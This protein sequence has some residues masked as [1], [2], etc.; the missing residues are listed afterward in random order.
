[1][2][3]R[4]ALQRCYRAIR[5]E[6]VLEPSRK[7]ADQTFFSKTDY[8]CQ[9]PGSA[10]KCDRRSV[11]GRW[12]SVGYLWSG[13]VSVGYRRQTPACLSTGSPYGRR[14]ARQSTGHPHGVRRELFTESRIA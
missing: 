7:P 4:D 12:I 11:V 2:T 3:V 6:R 1:M 8:C 10:I 14:V 5:V 9:I 13:D